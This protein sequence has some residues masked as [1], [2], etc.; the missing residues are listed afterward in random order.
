MGRVSDTP[1]FADGVKSGLGKSLLDSLG[2]EVPR[3]SQLPVTCMEKSNAH[4]VYSLQA[5][6]VLII[7]HSSNLFPGKG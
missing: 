1:K 3:H 6:L 4:G 7:S 5:F 2:E